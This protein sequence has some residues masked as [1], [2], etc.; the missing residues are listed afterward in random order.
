MALSR[1]VFSLFYSST[2][3]MK[4]RLSSSDWWFRTDLGTQS[5]HIFKPEDENESF[6]QEVD[7]F[8]TF[9]NLNRETIHF[10]IV[11]ALS[12]ISKGST[13]STPKWRSLIKGYKL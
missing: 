7:Y 3:Y 4:Q 5:F 11:N 9:D 1:L 8:S 12:L 6:G 10:Q 13:Q 2:A